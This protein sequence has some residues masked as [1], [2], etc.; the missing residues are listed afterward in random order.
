M[1]LF[2]KYTFKVLYFP[3]FDENRSFAK[4]KKKKKSHEV[5]VT[6]YRFEII[7]WSNNAILK[8]K[9]IRE[10][11]DLKQKIHRELYVLQGP[12]IGNAT[13]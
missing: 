3:Y 6:S 7:S 2:Y 12:F 1:K 11:T 5:V 10:S 8:S 13:V 9:Q 4:A